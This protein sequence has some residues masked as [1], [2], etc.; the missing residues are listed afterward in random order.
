MFS[1]SSLILLKL[2]DIVSES[3]NSRTASTP[4]HGASLL[5]VA[6]D[7]KN[8]AGQETRLPRMVACC[9]LTE[10]FQSELRRDYEPRGDKIMVV[11]PGGFEPLWYE[12]F[13]GYLVI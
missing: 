9:G 13:A 7:G 5:P 4:G 2:Q 3:I 11:V 10:R 1:R 12:S 8:E 6:D